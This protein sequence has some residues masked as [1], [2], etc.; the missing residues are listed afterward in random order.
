MLQGSSFENSESTSELHLDTAIQG[1]RQAGFVEH[2][3]RGL[4]S[5]AFLRTVQRR[6][7]DARADLNEANHLAE[8]GPMPLHL[9]DVCLHRARLFFRDNAVVAKAEIQAAR[10]LIDMHGYRR[11]LQELEDAENAFFD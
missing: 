1:L 9:A 4:L 7:I 8:R 11:R 3:P 10:T 5:R 6:P 2:I